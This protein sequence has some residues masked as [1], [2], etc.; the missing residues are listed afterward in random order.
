MTPILAADP[1]NVDARVALADAQ[2]FGNKPFAARDN[3]K[4]VLAADSSNVG[5]KNGLD[6]TRRATRP[7]VG[8]SYS[9]YND[10]NGVRLK[11][12]NFGPTIRTRGGVIGVIAEQGR[13]QQGPFRTDRSNI[14]L[15]YGKS[16]GPIQATAAVSRLK[17]DG[18]GEKFLYDLSLVNS[19]V[20]RR[21][22]YLGTG[23]RD[24]FQSAQAVAQ[25]ITET[26][27]R[28]GFNVP[29]GSR[30]DFETQGV[31][32]NYSDDNS[33]Y[34]ILPA[35]YYRFSPTNPS[36]RVGLGYAYDDTKNLRNI[37]YT[38]AGL[39]GL[40]GVGRLLE[41]HRQDALRLQRGHTFDQRDWHQRR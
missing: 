16:F 39:L 40:L 19:S 17:Y 34:S 1:K 13:F 4:E 27:Y 30:L 10:T 32:Y 33:R 11:S 23:R 14:G 7:S 21:R 31:Y 18:V 25:G 37:Y 35:L 22:Y 20:E 2:R 26:T 38:P 6:A 3:Y 8:V 12:V 24:V 28:G 29:I 15:T 9:V 41:Q 36:L 5:A